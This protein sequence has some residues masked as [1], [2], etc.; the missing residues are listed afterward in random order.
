MTGLHK[1]IETE[2]LVIEELGVGVAVVVLLVL[3]AGGLYVLSASRMQHRRSLLSRFTLATC[4]G[5]TSG[6]G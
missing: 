5:N 4:K 6:L 1:R 2:L 3:L